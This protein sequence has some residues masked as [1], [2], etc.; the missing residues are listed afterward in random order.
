MKHFKHR[1]FFFLIL[2]LIPGLAL[3][4]LCEPI[5]SV[6]KQT[7]TYAPEGQMTSTLYNT[8]TIVGQPL[9]TSTSTNYSQ[10][11]TTVGFFADYLTEPKAPLVRASDGDYQDKIYLEW[12]I[13]GDRTGPPITSNQVTVYRNGQTLTTLPISQTD[14]QDFNVFPGMSYNYGVSVENEMGES[15]I[16]DDAGFL[17]PNGMITGH[18]ET[19][20]G[21]PVPETKVMLTPNL[22]RSAYFERS[23]R[24]Y[25]YWFDDTLNTHRQFEGLE[26]DYTIETWFRSNEI[27]KQVLFAAVDSAS[28]NHY[29]TLRITPEGTIKWIH[30]PI[31]GENPTTITTSDSYVGPGQDWHHLAVVYEDSTHSMRMYID[32]FL[33]GEEMTSAGI[34]D[35]VEIVLGKKGPR[36]PIYYLSG[37]LDDFR[38]WSLPRSWDDLRNMMDITL[39]GDEEGLV[40]YW[41][42]DEADGETVFDLTSSNLDG[43]T[44]NMERDNFRAP[45]YLGAIS[46]DDGNY[47]IQGIYYDEGK[48]FNVTPSLASPIGRSLRFDG[49]DD[50]IQFSNEV[51]DLSSSF[52]IEG[53][54]KTESQSNLSILTAVD[55]VDYAHQLSIGI[56]DGNLRVSHFTRL[57]TTD[58]PDNEKLND[59]LWHH[60]AVTSDSERYRIY[61]DG[62]DKGSRGILENTQESSEL[63]IAKVSE[64]QG[65]NYYLGNLDEF[66]F[67]NTNRSVDEI[68]GTMNQVLDGD[69][70]G[71]ENYWRFNDGKD[72]LVS[73]ATG[74]MT[75]TI[76][77]S[78]NS[79][80]NEMWSKDIP[81]NEYFHHTY[82]P[83]SRAVAL[84]SSNTA[85]NAVDFTDNSMIPVSG[86]VRYANSSCFQEGVEILL[87]GEHLI[88]PP[89]TDGTGKFVLDL[90]PGRIGDVISCSFEDHEFGPPRIELPMI[91]QPISNLFFDD[92]KTF[93]LTG[94]VAGGTCKYGLYSSGDSISIT[95][96]SVD[97]CFKKT[98][99]P[100]TTNGEYEFSD[101]PPTIY[102]ISVYHSDLDIV[103]EADTVSLESSNRTKDF[104]YHSP[105]QI[106]FTGLPQTEV[107]SD[108]YPLVLSQG[109]FY[110]AFFEVFE[111]YGSNHCL[112]DTFHLDITDNI[113]DTSYSANLAGSEP[114]WIQ[115]TGNQVNLLSGG[116]YP[117]QNSLEITATDTSGRN[118]S[119]TF[120]ALIMGDQIIPGVN[121]STTTSKVPWYVLRVPPGDGSSTSLSSDQT[122]CYT[123]NISYSIDH[124]GHSNNTLHTGTQQHILSAAG[125]GVQIGTITDIG[126]TVDI[127]ANFSWNRT[128]VDIDE[129]CDCLTT[130]EGYE[131]SSDGLSSDEATVFIGGGYTV[132]LGMARNLSVDSNGAAVIEEVITMNT[133]GVH[134]TYIHNKYEIVNVLMP[135]LLDLFEDG[136]N[137]QALT[138]YEY[139]QYV[140]DL[141]S[142]AIA[143]AEFNDSLVLGPDGEA[144]GNIS[145]G[146]GSSVEYSYSTEATSTVAHTMEFTD[147]QEFFLETGFDLL[148]AGWTLNVG[149]SRTS[150]DEET[151]SNET[152][153]SRSIGFVLDDDDP[154]DVFALSVKS[155]PTWGMPV[156]ELNGGETSCPYELGT[157]RRQVA[158]L[159]M[160]D[161]SL[162][163][164]PP[165]EPAVFT[166]LLGN[167]SDTGE[168]DTYTLSA[169]NE[170]NPAS[171]QIYTTENLANGV[172]YTL[173]GNENLSVTLQVFRGPEVYEYDDL[174]LDLSPAC[175]GDDET[176]SQ[177]TFSVH[178]EEP[179]SKSNIADPEDGLVVN[180]SAVGNEL[181]VIINGYNYDPLDTFMTSLE[182]QYRPSSGGNWFR[183]DVVSVGDISND[184]VTLSFNHAPEIIS[185]G[186]WELRSQA[187]CS[188]GKYPG[189][190]E[191]ITILIDRSGPQVLG[192]PEPVDGILESNDLIRINFD[193]TINCDEIIQANGDIRLINTSNNNGVDFEYSCGEN[194]III[195][196]SDPDRF[197]ENLILRAEINNLQDMYGN[198][199]DESIS[200]EF[201]VNRNPLE[202]LGSDITNIVLEVDDSFST[203]RQ[204]VN[205]GGSNRSWSLI[206]GRVGDTP[207]GAPEDLPDWL[208]VSPIEGILTPGAAQDITIS[209][210][211]GLSYGRDS[212]TLYAAGTMG[213]EPLIIDIRRLCP[214]PEWTFNPSDYQYSMNIT[215]NLLIDD[216]VLDPVLSVD[217]FDRI[218]VFVGNELRGIAGVT[219][220]E[221]LSELSNIHPYEIFLTIYSN[222]SSGEELSFRVWD[223]SECRELGWIEEFYVFN[224]NSVYGSPTNPM[225]IT[226]T[227]KIV[228]NMAVSD[229]WSWISLNLEAD[230]MSTN[231]VTQFMQLS[232]NDLIKDQNSFSM[233]V[234]GFGWV[235]TLDSI[236]NESMYQFKLAEPDSLLFVGYAKDPELNAISIS[237]GWNWIGYIPQSSYPVNDALASLSSST[238]DLIKSQFAY[239]Q[240]VEG[241]GWIGNLTYMEPELGY[242]L[243]STDAGELIYPFYDEESSRTLAK[244]NFEPQLVETSPEWT[245]N[246]RDYEFNMN[247]TGLLFTHDSVSQDGYDMIGAFVGDECR[248]VA[249]PVFFEALD[250]HMVFMNVYGNAE[251]DDPV[252]FKAYDA[253]ADEELYVEESVEF[254]PNDIQGTIDE[255]FVWGARYLGIGDRGYIPEEFSL[256]QNFPNP[257]NPITTMGFG[258][259]EDSHVTIRIYNLLGQEIRTLVDTDFTA[260]YRFV[261]WN[262]LDDH[263]RLMTSGIYLVVMESGS[264][265]KVHKILMLK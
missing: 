255:P 182:L 158:N 45:V 217:E 39:S 44:C 114:G 190:S 176:S 6:H 56:T 65:S 98:I 52:T 67:W 26:Q 244:Q 58:L 22:G 83:E 14:Y 81:L 177:V 37:R 60:F 240:F 96:E 93:D 232:N 252:F 137:P 121:F 5:Y 23:Q 128:N 187:R 160:V 27:R 216:G 212:T 221:D 178:F 42:F 115:F 13:E 165:D 159:S 1:S 3:T 199:I 242:V 167:D 204:I 156:F 130:S 105:L 191:T 51:V 214:E 43:A 100:D 169:V 222:V 40:A 110:T 192:L 208:E 106:E 257:F 34:A 153:K 126:F 50:Y 7:R 91:V 29:I 234:E 223:A 186:Y 193:E 164:I 201:F 74:R 72:N 20:S 87:N 161:N 189:T 38:I 209:M 109:S 197:L 134:S 124:A 220:M 143:N 108:D 239:A 102:N 256:S 77:G 127:G 179:C 203:T 32:G 55:P 70:E 202:W 140:L 66:R 111:A 150:T 228:S 69:E 99:V 48:S 237:S 85:V 16:D 218:G 123:S 41:K 243:K 122:I 129:T 53:W 205:N 103:F 46:N 145:F 180:G 229:G 233:Y 194:A 183:A 71:L 61:L 259:P 120:W 210:V 95:L 253:S 148:G 265:R 88:P 174:V 68:N 246:P 135:T 79:D 104:I 94:V 248:G 141:D 116:D 28:I 258:L 15:Q 227:N 235:G 62:V 19:P 54:L 224:A 250:Q 195:D 64:Q 254:I 236:R 241:L 219:Y 200:W 25:V 47:V 207:S 262:S 75:G 149:Y 118:S 33:V 260:G 263:G 245:V 264:Y 138:D 238:G 168:S 226:A 125:I 17:N 107:E 225:N 117:F 163:N 92:L 162:S 57:L 63:S 132:D 131:T 215:A 11:S 142:S 2:G 10:Y 249:Q 185:D 78:L 206:G 261:E 18:I 136:D 21:N 198:V 4:Q 82:E 49:L 80:I 119:A 113:S 139:W 144:T 35:K 188:G 247:I 86:Y 76:V 184:Q 151:Q 166:L 59:N 211:D 133:T 36:E 89:Y 213:D 155:D 84:N 146:A 30:Q 112:I 24:S 101:L 170:S 9:I 8:I 175:G 173:E 12:D 97:G 157:F 230:D 147:A 196:P 154:G 152:T 231:A 90:E 73:D 31:A 251:E 171:A 181:P 172:D